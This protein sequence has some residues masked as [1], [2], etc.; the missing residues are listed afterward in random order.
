MGFWINCEENEVLKRREDIMQEQLTKSDVAKIE[1]EI[2]HR[3]LVV[4]KEA[5]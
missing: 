4:R 3:K 2:E 1:A 5:I